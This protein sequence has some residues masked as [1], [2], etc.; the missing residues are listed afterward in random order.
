ME[1][2]ELIGMHKLSGVN[3]NTT[4]IRGENVNSIAFKLD[5]ITYLAV[6][7]P[8]DG[9]R[10]YMDNLEITENTI[11]NEFE[12]IEVMCRMSD[13]ADDN[14]L[15]MYDAKTTLTVLR[16]GT[17]NTDDYYPYCVFEYKPENMILNKRGI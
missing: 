9:Y 17:E 15:E 10:S 8:S 5:D 12:A 3:L 2:K 13:V 1:L 14:V 11:S 16:I 6:E 4:K 7:D